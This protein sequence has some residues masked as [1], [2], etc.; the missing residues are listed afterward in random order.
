[1]HNIYTFIIGLTLFSC[2]WKIQLNSGSIFSNSYN[3]C[4]NENLSL[5]AC[6]VFTKHPPC[7]LQNSKEQNKGLM[8][9]TLYPLVKNSGNGEFVNLDLKTCF[10]HRFVPLLPRREKCRDSVRMLACQTHRRDCKW[11]TWV[12]VLT[13]GFPKVHPQL[14]VLSPGTVLLLTKSDILQD[15]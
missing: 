5:L 15:P 8:M 3:G 9:E 6:L 13:G 12:S 1:M 14:Q 11:V 4:C 2:S 7:A 10:A